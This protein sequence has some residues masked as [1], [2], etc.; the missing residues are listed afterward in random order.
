MNKQLLAEFKIEGK[1]PSYNS[2]FKINYNLKLIY[3]TQTA[4]EFK[5]RVKILSPYISIPEHCLIQFKIQVIQSWI[6]KN[7]KL[8]RADVQNMDKLL[9]DAL[10]DKW[11][12]D[13]SRVQKTSIEKIH[14]NK[15]NYINIKIWSIDELEGVD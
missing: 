11:G 12:I 13:D 1:C 6:Y 10:C 4:R 14:S 8:K 2:L 7:G 9:I 15:E 5:R 3:L